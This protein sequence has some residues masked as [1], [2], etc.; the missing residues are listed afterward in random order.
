MASLLLLL[1]IAFGLR[2]GTEVGRRGPLFDERWITRPI[3]ELLR[4]GWSVET[5]VDFQETK[6]PGLIWPY[7]AVGGLLIEDPQ[8]VAGAEAPPGGRQGRLPDVWKPPVEGGPAP[9]P[10]G[11]LAALRLVS[12]LCFVLSGVPLLVLAAACGIRG[13]PLFVVTLLLALLPQEAIFGQLVMGEASFV[14]LSLV[15]VAVVAW[16]MGVGNGT[17]HRVAGPVVAAVVLAVMLH[18][19]PHA[20]AWAPAIC[21]AAFARESWRSWPWWVAMLCAGLLRIPL[22]MRWGG[23]VGSDFQNL[24]GLGIRLESLTYLAAA[25]ALPLGVFLV[26][27]LVG[28][29]RR[30]AVWVAVGVGAGLVLGLI[31]PVM[32]S[33]HGGLDL[34]VQH[35]RYQGVAATMARGVAGPG[36]GGA[37]VIAFMAMVGLGGLGALFA[38]TRRRSPR[39]VAGAILR[40]QAWVL[41]A[42]WALYALTR[43]FVFDRYLLAW[44]ALL[45]IAWVLTLP[46]WL[47]GVQVAMLGGAAVWFIHTWLM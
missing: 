41:L 5:A 43:G 27:W 15:L 39:E 44:S 46:R 37:A 13:P 35:D 26:A 42:G 32:P 17:A 16:G 25:M 23:L 2:W 38:E 34:A 8:E 12:V 4:H 20:V 19:R 1:L 14:L 45:P 21:L 33:L 11:M 29:C 6:G 24:H 7:A 40:V 10:P 9:A 28:P 36:R 3:A 47:L 30:G 22:W 18:S 31:A